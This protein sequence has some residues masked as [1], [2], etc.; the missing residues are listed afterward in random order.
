MNILVLADS[1][2]VAVVCMI[3]VSANTLDLKTQSSFL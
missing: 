1:Y 2:H 3:V